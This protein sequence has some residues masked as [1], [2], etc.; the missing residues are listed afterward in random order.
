VT[1]TAGTAA[2]NGWTVKWNL[3]G[4]QSIGSTWNGTFTTSGSSVTVT[5]VAYNGALTA[6]A[7]TSFG[8]VGTGTPS[9]PTAS[10]TSP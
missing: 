10:C 4:G 6:K 2:I 7:S 3:A 9:T 5:N 8:F 1:V